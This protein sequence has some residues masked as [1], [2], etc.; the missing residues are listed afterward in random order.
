MKVTEQTLR[1]IVREEI[2]EALGRDISR[3]VEKALKDARLK[4]YKVLDATYLKDMLYIQIE[5]MSVKFDD[6]DERNLQRNHII[7][8]ERA[9]KDEYEDY[10]K[11]ADK[12]LPANPDRTGN[13]VVHLVLQHR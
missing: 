13:A 7:P 11:V 9:L 8:I 3:D 5:L 2:T 6:A 4:Y 12:I 1:K 10:V